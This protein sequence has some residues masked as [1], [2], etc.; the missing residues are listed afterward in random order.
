MYLIEMVLELEHQKLRNVMASD[1]QSSH[2]LTV[3]FTVC[4]LYPMLYVL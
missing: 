4:L 1:G 2:T 3:Y